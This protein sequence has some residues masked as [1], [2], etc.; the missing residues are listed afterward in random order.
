MCEELQQHIA[1][2]TGRSIAAP[3]RDQEQQSAKVVG[4]EQHEEDQEENRDVGQEEGQQD[5][6]GLRQDPEE[7]RQAKG[8]Q[9]SGEPASAR[10]VL[11]EAAAVPDA[12]TAGQ[13]RQRA[14][15]KLEALHGRLEGEREEMQQRIAACQEKYEALVNLQVGGWGWAGIPGGA[16]A[17]RVALAKHHGGGTICSQPIEPGVELIVLMHN[18]RAP[19]AHVA[20]GGA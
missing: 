18:L 4:Q 19:G 9:E 20:D 17:E 13:T 12:A 6:L 2:L 1:E 7:P 16:I 3:T 5:G 15:E 10:K 8:E 14:F 11:P